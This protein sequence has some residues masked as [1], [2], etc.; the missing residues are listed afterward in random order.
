MLDTVEKL[1]RKHGATLDNETI[2]HS[3]QGSHYTSQAFIE[4]LKDAE[5]VQSMSRRGNCWDNAPQESFFG[6][7]KDHIEARIAEM[8]EYDQVVAQ[9]DDYIDYYNN[10]AGQMSLKKLAP[11]EYYKYLQ[12]GKYPLP[13]WNKRT[14]NKDVDNTVPKG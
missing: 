12:T 11:C 1:I 4:K 13:V 10:D 9:V 3:D 7:M 6:H 2:V 14:D 5:F 8:T